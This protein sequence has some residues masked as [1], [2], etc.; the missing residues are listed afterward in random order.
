ML[1]IINFKFLLDKSMTQSRI[2]T[3]INIEVLSFQQKIKLKIFI[4][5]SLFGQSE[6]VNFDT[7]FNVIASTQFNLFNNFDIYL[8]FDIIKV[9]FLI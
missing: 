7:A 9:F 6:G 5:L 1:L 8:I 3:Y 4:L 2:I